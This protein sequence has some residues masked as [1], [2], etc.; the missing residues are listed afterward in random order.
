MVISLTAI[1]DMVGHISII[2]VGWDSLGALETLAKR[3]RDKPKRKITSS[4][5]SH[6]HI[7]IFS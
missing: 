1:Q 4:P 5:I 6:S 3:L 2:Y 7:F